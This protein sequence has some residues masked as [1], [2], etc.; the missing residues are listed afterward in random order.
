MGWGEVHRRRFSASLC[1]AENFWSL[2]STF[3]S[4]IIPPPHAQLH[5]NYPP[6]LQLTSWRLLFDIFFLVIQRSPA[7]II[8]TRWS[9]SPRKPRLDMPPC[10]P[11]LDFR[12]TLANRF[13]SSRSAS[14]RLLMFPE[15]LFTSEIYSDPRVWEI[16]RDW[17]VWLHSGYLPLIVYLGM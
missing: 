3:R 7:H 12:H 11:S 2:T 1:G 17:R 13:S 10:L 5:E 16:W 14:P 4:A 15:S 9:N 6:G 8:S